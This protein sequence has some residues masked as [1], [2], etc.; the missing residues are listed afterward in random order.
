[1]SRCYNPENDSFQHYGGR[2]IG[3][4]NEWQDFG[5][6]YVD[7]LAYEGSGLTL[8]RK[9]NNLGYSK[10]NCRWVDVTVQ[11]NN[12]RNNVNVTHLGETKTLAQ[13]AE[14]F[15]VN[16]FTLYSRYVEEQWSFEKS[17]YS[18]DARKLPKDHAVIKKT[19]RWI[20]YMGETKTLSQWAESN[21]ID[22]GTL[23]SRLKAGWSMSEAIAP[24]TRKRKAKSITAMGD[25]V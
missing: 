6:F 21:S 25:T 23:W 16:Y 18:G 17:I 9:D 24:G 13:W 22:K 5:T 12:R 11:N 19:D 15:G 4:S 8:D 2:G 1:M 10:E 20:E 3:V 7:N 14:V